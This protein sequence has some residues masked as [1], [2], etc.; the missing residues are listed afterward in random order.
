MLLDNDFK[1]KIIKLYK[2]KLS[3]AFNLWRVNRSA[4]VIEMQTMQFE[5]IQGQNAEVEAMVRENDV[6]IKAADRS[7]KN[8]GA[9]HI[10]KLVTAAY[11]RNMKAYL[12]RWRSKNS[13]VNTQ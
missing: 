9:K 5:D 7:C 10:K 6:K 13:H 3:K 4:M 1:V 2:G 12:N 8:N 11:Q